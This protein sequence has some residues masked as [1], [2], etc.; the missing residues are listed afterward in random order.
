MAFPYGT[1]SGGE[2]LGRLRLLSSAMGPSDHRRAGEDRAAAAGG[3]LSIQACVSA[4]VKEAMMECWFR[5]NEL[6][7][8][9]VPAVVV[10]RDYPPVKG[11]PN[12]AAAE[13]HRLAAS[14]EIH[15]YEKDHEPADFREFPP[16]S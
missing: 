9:Y 16:R 13:L 10:L 11:Q 12:V 6:Q 2:A 15:W 1:L 8:R 5:G 7:S 3:T 4:G 14:G